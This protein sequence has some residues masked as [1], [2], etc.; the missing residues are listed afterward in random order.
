MERTEYTAAIL[1]ASETKEAERFLR[2]LSACTRNLLFYPKGHEVLKRSLQSVYD[3]TISLMNGRPELKVGL[4]EN[5][6]IVYSTVLHRAGSLASD[7]KARLLERQLTSI[8]LAAT[9]TQNDLEALADLLTRDPE[10]VT[11]EGATAILRSRGAAAVTVGH[12]AKASEIVRVEE[13]RDVQAPVEEHTEPGFLRFSAASISELYSEAL[14]GRTDLDGAR[15]MLSNIKDIVGSGNSNIKTMIGTKSHDDYTYTHIVNVCVLTIAQARRMNLSNELL[16][17]IGLAALMHDVGKQRVPG[18]IIR[19][20]SR[21]TPQEFEIMKNHTVFGAEMLLEMRGAPDLAAIVAFEHHLRYDCQGYPKIRKRR[22][23]NLCTYLTMIADAF[24]AM[25][26]LRP[27]SN[28]MSQEEVAIRM[29]GDA[30]THF[31]P[32]LLGGFFRMLDLFPSGSKVALST[33]EEA[34]IVKRARQ[35]YMR[36][37]V[38]VTRD[39]D[40]RQIDEEL[41]ID[42]MK[43]GVKGP[44]RIAASLEPSLDADSDKESGVEAA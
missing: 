4:L 27:Y 28:K 17:D 39:S 41:L 37:V 13:T 9:L 43:T 31:E 18:E 7:L 11:L 42:L 33:G 32:V 30:G 12:L 15:A 29:A 25:R 21:L 5:E 35:D 38:R 1:D 2:H 44:V 22:R 6:W 10:S 24:D 34:V 8:T 16:D 14:E 19:K 20:P 26:T 3:S 36:P 40:G 23:L